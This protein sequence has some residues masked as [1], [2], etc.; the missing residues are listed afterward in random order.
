[1]RIL[2][3]AAACTLAGPLAAEEVTV[4]AAAS[5]KTALDPIAARFEERTGHQ[6]TLVLAGSN[7]LARQI[8]E[9]APADIFLSA[10]PE[11][12]DVV[13][14][15]RLVVPGTRSDLLG[16]ALVL[17]TGDAGASPVTIGP[18]LDLPALLDDGRIAMALVDSVPAGQYGKAALTSLGLWNDAAARVAQADNVRAALALVTTGEAPLG[19][20]YATDAAADPAV[21]VVGRFPPESHPPI[22]YPVALL[23]GAGDDADRAFLR[24]LSEPAAQQV[25]R[26]QGFTLAP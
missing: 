16:N 9:G 8:V 20:V 17:V 26:E 12:M 3:L 19:V 18:D 5:L 21:T 11:W 13:E 22:T 25:F 6:V 24:T 23:S 14:A 4:F 7:L 2:L 15:E 10:S 1:M